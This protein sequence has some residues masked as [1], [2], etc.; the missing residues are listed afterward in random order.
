M[1]IG[2][3][4]KSRRLSENARPL[5][6]EAI[7]KAARLAG[8]YRRQI[9]EPVMLSTAIESL[10]AEARSVP[11]EGELARRGNHPKGRIERCGPCPKCGGDDRFSINTQKG[12][13]NCR[14]CSKG[15]DVIDLVQH[16]DGV[17]FIT[18]CETLTGK[19]RANGH[20][21]GHTHNAPSPKP[22]EV[23]LHKY[24]DE[25]GVVRFA[26]KRFE[27]Q[28][29]DG[30]FVQKDGKRQKTF[31]QMRPDPDRPGAWINNLDG[32]D[33]AIPYRLPDLLKAADL[34][35]L[36]VIVEGERKADLLWSW[37]I[38][39]TTNA[40]GAGKWTAAHSKYLNGADVVILPDNDEPGRQ[41]AENVAALLRDI[42]INVRVLE[43][44]DLGPKEDIID[45][46][47]RGGDVRQL[48]ELIA[49]RAKPWRENGEPAAP[50][51]TEE[52]QSICAADVKIKA[53]EWLWPDRFAVGKLGILAGMP[54]EG[55]GQIFSYIIAMITTGGLWPCNE[56]RAPKGNVLLLTAEDDLSDTVV[57]RLVAAGADLSR[58]HFVQMVTDVQDKNKKEH[59]FSLIT[60]LSKLR[61]KI[62]AIGDV[63]LVMIDPIS[64]YMGVKQIDS[65]RTGDVRSVLG[66]VVDMAAKLRIAF[67]GIMHFNKKTDVNN[68]LLRISDS[69]AYGATAR[70]VY[71]AINDPENKRKLFVKAKNNLAKHDQQSLAY[72]F[73]SR[74]VGRDEE[75]GV[76]IAAPYI[77]W[78]PQPVGISASEAMEAATNSKAPKERTSAIEFLKEFL[79]EG[80]KFKK[81]VEEAADANM[82]SSATLRRA[83]DELGII[84]EKE[85]G[86]PNGQWL[87]RLPERASKKNWND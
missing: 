52:L 76:D 35:K 42:A 57:P 46:A 2:W 7:S 84:A 60:D 5:A 36:I 53:I 40:M 20:A 8:G 68:A 39:A 27:Y 24:P 11:I 75:L 1:Q 71:A 37:G 67:L 61:R 17:D 33:T 69:L 4:T 49:T 29:A 21:N 13:W 32:V 56:G 79:A 85:R 3:T 30:S 38:A 45:W 81:E 14:N 55:K 66:P 18:A 74:E 26:V 73:G 87:W 51:D 19:R 10:A 50:P 64:A 78:D 59:M 15:G 86:V 9:A 12:V 41:H 43:L 62:E 54:D 70:H 34:G 77:E 47:K 16:L 63:R 44:P 28:N 65:F 23:E 31:R 48:S 82:I 6:R 80:P 83:K 25:H 72:H 58:V 22:V